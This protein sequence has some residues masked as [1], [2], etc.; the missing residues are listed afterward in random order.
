MIEKIKNF[1]LSPPLMRFYRVT[2][3][4]IV[5]L[6]LTNLVTLLGNLEIV[7]VSIRILIVTGLTGVITSVDK[8][9]RD[10]LANRKT[11]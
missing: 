4:G 5:S 7:D 6:F 3:Y 11:K 9:T 8:L 10:M 2:G 1:F